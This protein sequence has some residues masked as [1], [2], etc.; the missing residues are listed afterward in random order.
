MGAFLSNHCLCEWNPETIQFTTDPTYGDRNVTTLTGKTALVT[1]ASRGIGRATAQALASAGARVIVHY[2]LAAEEAD[3]VVAGVRAAGG[4]AYA[5]TADLS[6]PE[7]A[8][9]VAQDGPQG[10]AAFLKQPTY[11]FVLRYIQ[12]PAYGMDKD[13]PKLGPNTIDAVNQLANGCK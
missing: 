13:H 3:A 7:G 6:V 4:L 11:K 5:V 8:A 2:G 9:I 1:G 12:L 10:L